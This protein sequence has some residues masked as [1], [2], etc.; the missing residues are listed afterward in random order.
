MA[1]EAVV[2]LSQNDSRAG[3]AVPGLSLLTSELGEGLGFAFFG[4]SIDWSD[5]A[6]HH[7]SHC[8]NSFRL[9]PRCRPASCQSEAARRANPPC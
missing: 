7:E 3:E 1:S 4:R 5:H 6:V 8:R 9:T 2:R